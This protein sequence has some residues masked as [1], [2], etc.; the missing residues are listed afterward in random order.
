MN[1]AGQAF[2]G[3]VHHADL[4]GLHLVGVLAAHSCSANN[5]SGVLNKSGLPD[6]GSV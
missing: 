1:V 3:V 6:N 4:V 2:R 5:L